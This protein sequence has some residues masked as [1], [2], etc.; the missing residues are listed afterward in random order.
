[1]MSETKS[2]PK[3][4]RAL[5]LVLGI[6]AGL[7]TL[8]V[9]AYLAFAL[10]SNWFSKA[11]SVSDEMMMMASL[12]DYMVKEFPNRGYRFLNVASYLGNCAKGISAADMFKYLGTPDLIA[13][14]TELGTLAYLYDQPGATNKWAVY[15][16]FDQ[17]KLMRLVF[18]DST[19][20]D[21][22]AYRAYS[23]P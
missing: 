15:A 9:T 19:A 21:P 10:W 12:G 11:T 13:G 2:N 20:H 5:R 17:G 7:C 16:S 3:W 18:N 22:S 1:M 4:K 8:L 23:A 6:Y 14:T